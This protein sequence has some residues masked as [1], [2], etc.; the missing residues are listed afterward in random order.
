M[1]VCLVIVF[2]IISGLLFIKGTLVFNGL[3]AG[4]ELPSDETVVRIEIGNR[5]NENI[6][7]IESLNDVNDILTALSK[8]KVPIITSSF[9]WTRA[10]HDRPTTG[11]EYLSISIFGEHLYLRAFL[12]TEVNNGYVYV[13]YKGVYKIEPNIIDELRQNYIGSE[14]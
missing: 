8:T 11:I 2:V 5:A 9:F 6:V 10:A 14:T 1:L 3:N 13:P 12:Y 7:I 4:I